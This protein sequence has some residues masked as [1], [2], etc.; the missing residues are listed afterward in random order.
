MEKVI[1]LLSIFLLFC[2]IGWVIEVIYRSSANKHFVNPGFMVGICLPIY[3]FGGLILYLIFKIN[4]GISSIY[5]DVFLKVLIAAII[6]TAIEFIGGFI[7]LKVYHNR[8]WDYRDK[9]F[10][11]MG[12]VCPKFSFYWA[13]LSLAFYL[14][15]YSWLDTFTSYIYS[16]NFMIL[17]LGLSLGIF[18]VDLAYSIKLLDKIRA[19]AI[20][21]QENVVFENLKRQAKEKTA[22]RIEKI[23]GWAIFKMASRISHYLDEENQKFQEKR[24]KRDKDNHNN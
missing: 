22:L 24:N 18:L 10:N 5:L 23:R 19:Y 17:L 2:V 9:K 6:L 20:R 4:M 15:V 21:I 11:I 16:H 3:G 14:L 1:A 12:L 7:S 13:I 8:L